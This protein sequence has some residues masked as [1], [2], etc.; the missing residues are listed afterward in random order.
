MS[1][2]VV[3]SSLQV[4]HTVAKVCRFFLVLKSCLGLTG[5]QETD[6]NMVQKMGTM[7]LKWKVS[8]SGIGHGLQNLF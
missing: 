6:E 8:N 5:I 3:P 2:F 4:G 1:S 7:L